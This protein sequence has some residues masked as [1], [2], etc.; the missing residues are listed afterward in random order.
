VRKTYEVD[1]RIGV[2]AGHRH[3][4]RREDVRQQFDAIAW[5]PL[6]QTPSVEK[7]Q[8]LLHLQARARAEPRA[9]QLRVR[10]Q[11]TCLTCCIRTCS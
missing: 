11:R 4:V 3:Q 7:C 10:V 6:G 5:L 9:R 2:Y 8:D 1:E